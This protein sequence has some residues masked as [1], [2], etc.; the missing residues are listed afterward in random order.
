[1]LHRVGTA[2]AGDEDGERPCRESGSLDAL[3]HRLAPSIAVAIADIGSST[4]ARRRTLATHGVAQFE[5]VDFPS[6]VIRVARAR[7]QVTDS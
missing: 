5:Q 2:D 4:S 3:R 6:A 7:V 1:V